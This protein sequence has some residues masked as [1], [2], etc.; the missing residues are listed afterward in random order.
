MDGLIVTIKELGIRSTIARTLN[1]E[2]LIIPNS[3]LVQAR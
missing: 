1:E 2:D 3:I